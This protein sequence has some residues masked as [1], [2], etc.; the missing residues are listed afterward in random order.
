MLKQNRPGRLR[1]LCS[2]L[3]S[4]SPAEGG[5]YDAW[6]AQPANVVSRAASGIADF[7]ELI[8]KAQEK[9]PSRRVAR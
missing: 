9:A 7:N 1:T 5:R 3:C 6:V 8:A 4:P 2:S